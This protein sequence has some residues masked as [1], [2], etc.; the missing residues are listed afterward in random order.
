M[1]KEVRKIEIDEKEG[2]TDTYAY[3]HTDRK[4]LYE[5]C[6]ILYMTAI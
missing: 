4:N 5:D 6:V 3:R 2:E 1:E